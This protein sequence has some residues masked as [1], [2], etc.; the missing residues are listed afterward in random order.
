[1]FDDLISKH[2]AN[3]LLIDTH[4]MLLLVIGIYDRRRMENFKRTAVYTRQDFQRMGWLQTRFDKLWITPNI[5][6]EV[7]NLGRQLPRSEGT[8]FSN[9]LN[10][11]SLKMTETTSLPIPQWLGHHLRDWAW[12]I[13]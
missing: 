12:Q 13:M 5:L 9:A 8:G 7:D 2:R 6:T 1:M 10:A 11:L 4:L 3:G